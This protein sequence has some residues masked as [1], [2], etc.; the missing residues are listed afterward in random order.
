MKLEQFSLVKCILCILICAQIENGHCQRPL[1]GN[2]TIQQAQTMTATSQSPS[3]SW[4]SSASS[5]VSSS[6]KLL[7]Q[8]NRKNR[9]TK[10]FNNP[11]NRSNSSETNANLYSPIDD[12]IFNVNGAAASSPVR[13]YHEL[14]DQTSVQ[15]ASGKY[16]L[17][18]GQSSSIDYTAATAY[19]PNR[20]RKHAFTDL[21][22][23]LTSGRA[24]WERQ[25]DDPARNDNNNPMKILKSKILKSDVSTMCIFV[26]R[27][28]E[29]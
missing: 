3:A 18:T 12:G 22:K 20:G 13:P 1:N 23:N 16:F 9:L 19:Q 2:D 25:G 4:P 26:L 27:S 11:S 29:N 7:H 28:A 21:R 8:L 24:L 5:S 14:D 6:T 17:S 10:Q 15:A